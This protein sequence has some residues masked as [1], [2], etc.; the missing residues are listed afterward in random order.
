MGVHIR[1]AKF[2]GGVLSVE[3]GCVVTAVSLICRWLNVN[4]NR[5][6][7]LGNG[8]FIIYLDSG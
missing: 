5:F 3:Q 8:R 2:P 6:S 1:G 4:V 7:Q